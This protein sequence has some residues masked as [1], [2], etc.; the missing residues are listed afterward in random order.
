MRGVLSW[1][2]VAALV[3]C[4]CTLSPGDWFATVAPTF[5]SRYVLRADRNVEEG[6]QKLNTLYEIKMTRATVTIRAVELHALGG[7]EQPG[8][9]DPSQPPD[10]YSL[11]HNGHCHRDD[12][13]LV[14]Y[15]VIAAEISGGDAVQPEIVATLPVGEQDLLAP[16]RRP[17][18]CDPRCGL[19]LTHVRRARAAITAVA[20]EGVVREGRAPARLEGEVVWRWE[21]ATLAEGTAEEPVSLDC[22]LDLPA[23]GAHP[24]KV[25]LDLSLQVG[26]RLF[27][28]IDWS[29]LGPDAGVIDFG[30][31]SNGA[32]RN[33]LREH[34]A[35]AELSAAI[36]RSN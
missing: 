8:A 30:V 5:E 16:A 17:L 14:P 4:G 22:P 26:A 1:S 9:F 21:A 36:K 19:P 32:A 29:A 12:G 25:S 18:S 6:W 23:D 10:G 34:L 15:E 31:E 33:R 24:P 2:G 11:C 13:A 27:D 35:E 7:A 3:A 20:F 28:D